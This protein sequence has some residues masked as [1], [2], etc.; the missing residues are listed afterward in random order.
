MKPKYLLAAL[1]ALTLSIPAFAGFTSVADLESNNEQYIAAVEA[2]NLPEQAALLLY[3]TSMDDDGAFVGG[4]EMATR[5]ARPDVSDVMNAGVMAILANPVAQ[6]VVNYEGTVR[7]WIKTPSGQ[8]LAASP[9]SPIPSWLSNSLYQ[10][11]FL[12]NDYGT[13]ELF[14]DWKAAGYALP[15]GEVARP[16]TIAFVAGRVKDWDTI[17]GLDRSDFTYEVFSFPLYTQWAKAQAE[18]KT[19]PENYAFVQNELV[20]VGMAGTP[21]SLVIVEH[22]GKLSQLMFNLMRQGAALQSNP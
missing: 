17:T 21:G 13:P 16:E 22:L 11:M 12:L 9:L 7:A 6:T 5:L 15:L 14:A 4:E 18:G 8:A 1:V 19:V 3:L 10:Y 20:T 2:G